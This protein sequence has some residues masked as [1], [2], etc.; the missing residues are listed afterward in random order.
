ME[1]KSIETEGV[2]FDTTT[3]T[4]PTTTTTTTTPTTTTTTT[5]TTTTTTTPTTTTTTTTAAP[6]TIEVV[7]DVRY[8][9]GDKQIQKKTRDIDTDAGAESG[10]TIIEGGQAEGC[11]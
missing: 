4:T 3:T 2:V 5:P 7:T 1:D 9:D 10:W 11:P 8:D 6:V